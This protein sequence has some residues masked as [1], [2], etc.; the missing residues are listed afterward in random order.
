MVSN[1]LTNIFHELTFFFCNSSV[2]KNY[3]KKFHISAP[4]E[5]TD[6]ALI[7]VS[8]SSDMSMTESP[9]SMALQRMGLG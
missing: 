8:P 1:D 5:H 2:S 4:L 3:Y 6:H 9:S 7:T